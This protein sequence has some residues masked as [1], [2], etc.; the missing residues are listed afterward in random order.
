MSEFSELIKKFDKIRDYMREFYVYGFKSR[1]DYDK[2]SLRSYDNEKR[3]IESY[4]SDY[5]SFRHDENNKNIFISIDSSDI[6]TNPLYRAFKAKSFT[7]NDITLNFII[8]DILDGGERHSA[9]E[10]ADKIADEYLTYFENPVIWDLST[11]RNKLSEYVNL[12]ILQTEKD[13]KRLLYSL[14]KTDINLD[15]LCDALAFFSEISPLGVVGSFLLDKCNYNNSILSFK[16]HYIMHALESEI[17]YT[18]LHAIH[19]KEKVEIKNHSP[20]SDRDIILEII[21]LKFLISAQ[22]GRRYLCA[23]SSKFR[24]IVDFRL[25]YIMSVKVLGK[26][27]NYTEHY[28]KLERIL[29]CTWSASFGNAKRLEWL[30]MKLSIPHNERFIVNRIE[31]EGRHGKLTQIDETTYEYF[32]EVFDTMEMMPWIR[33]FIGRIISIESSN[34]EVTQTFYSDLEKMYQLYNGGDGNAVQ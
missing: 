30:K 5:M 28:E 24:A 15:E 18:L 31:R 7:K 20:R 6:P 2:K 8:L 33:T 12:G 19:N 21:P 14:K 32:I 23:Y 26:A 34:I 4:L 17:V 27:N 11:V 29:S 22:G 25:D 16:H 3:R 10:V 1:E 13:G 9:N